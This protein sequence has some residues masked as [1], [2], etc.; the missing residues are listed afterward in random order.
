MKLGWIK[1]ALASVALGL[2]LMVPAGAAKADHGHLHFLIPSLV[3]FVVA[4]R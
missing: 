1:G 2:A 3:C 4:D